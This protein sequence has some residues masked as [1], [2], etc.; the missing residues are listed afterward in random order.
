M[1]VEV[2]GLGFTAG[3]GMA[4]S[5]MH[6]RKFYSLPVPKMTENTERYYQYLSSN[7]LSDISSGVT[8]KARVG[9]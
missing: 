7:F 8:T 3:A 5:L 6:Y 1:G 4:N 9:R 2:Y